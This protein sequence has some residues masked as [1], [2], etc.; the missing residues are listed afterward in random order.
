[1]RIK[2]R[3]S[4]ICAR[5]LYATLRIYTI[6]ILY[7]CIRAL[8]ILTSTWVISYD[9]PRKGNEHSYT[10]M[11]YCIH[12]H[13]CIKRRISHICARTLYATL[14]HLH[15]SYIL[16]VHQGATSCLLSATRATNA[17]AIHGRGLR[18][19]SPKPARPKGSRLARLRYRVLLVR[20][21]FPVPK[22]SCGTLQGVGHACHKEALAVLTKSVSYV[23]TYVRTSIS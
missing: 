9:R 2:R 23:F 12:S 17:A 11:P 20:C 13:M 15:H 1:M 8:F 14:T 16:L 19:A 4:H 7:R 3:I 6:P 10:Y 21:P 18:Q 5:T 22:P